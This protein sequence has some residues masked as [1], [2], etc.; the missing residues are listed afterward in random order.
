VKGPISRLSLSQSEK[1]IAGLLYDHE[2]KPVYDWWVWSFEERSDGVMVRF[3]DIFS[4]SSYEDKIPN[5]YGTEQ[6]K[7]YL[8]GMVV[9][10]LHALRIEKRAPYVGRA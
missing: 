4:R 7:G 1:E 10:Y 8:S 5:T 9:T 6:I 2:L 3:Y